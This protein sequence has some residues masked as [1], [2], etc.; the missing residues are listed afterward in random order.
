MKTFRKCLSRVLLF[1]FLV[2]FLQL[3]INYSKFLRTFLRL[4]IFFYFFIFFLFLTAFCYFFQKFYIIFSKLNWFSTI[5]WFPKNFIGILYHRLKFL[6]FFFLILSS[7]PQFLLYRL[8]FFVLFFYHFLSL[9]HDAL[10]KFENSRAI[11]QQFFLQILYVFFLILGR[12]TKCLTI[13]LNFF[14]LFY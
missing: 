6:V 12:F 9:L 11:Y 1:S 13:Y 8:G 2:G 5:F 4:S 7:F 3:Y 10:L 14:P